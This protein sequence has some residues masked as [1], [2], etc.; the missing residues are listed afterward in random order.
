ML[1]DC[2][3]QTS[4]CSVCRSIPNSFWSRVH[5][6]KE[7]CQEACLPFQSL[8]RMQAAAATGCSLCKTL[9][10]STSKIFKQS[11]CLYL[12]RS[13]SAPHHAI[14]L[15]VGRNGDPVSQVYFYRIPLWW[16][17]K[18]KKLLHLPCCCL[19]TSVEIAFRKS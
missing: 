1:T 14:T 16:C 3:M 7:H 2:S 4:L 6:Q 17:S 19:H 9:L 8:D 11:D 12:H 13:L 5:D 15:G 10:K 18:L